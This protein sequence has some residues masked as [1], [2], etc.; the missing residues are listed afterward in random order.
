MRSSC[1][2]DVGGCGGAK[3]GDEAG[4]LAAAFVSGSAV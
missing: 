4:G 3:A 2:G 1:V